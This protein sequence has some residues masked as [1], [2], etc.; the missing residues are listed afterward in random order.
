MDWRHNGFVVLE[1]TNT[2]RE[3]SLYHEIDFMDQ[4]VDIILGSNIPLQS[5]Y[6]TR[7]KPRYDYPNDHRI[8]AMFHSWQQEV[9]II[10][11]GLRSPDVNSARSRKCEARLLR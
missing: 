4:S 7:R 10:G 6:A 9:Y 3:Q 2:I 1:G 11:L 5:Y 8:L